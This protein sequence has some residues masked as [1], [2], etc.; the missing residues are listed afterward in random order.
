MADIYTRVTILEEQVADLTEQVAGLT[1]QIAGLT[2]QD[3]G[4]LDLPLINGVV[5]YTE[6]NKP[7]YRK[8]G[9]KVYLKGTVKNV[10]SS[11]TVIATLPEGFRPVR[12]GHSYTQNTSFN[13]GAQFSR[14]AVEVNG[15]IKIHSNSNNLYTA[16]NWCPIHTE[17]LTD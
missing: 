11:N 8:I 12:T 6:S 1:E 16:E 14:I 15:D 3:T 9:N 13:N 5:S 10:L 17:F 7:Q 4:W 2:V